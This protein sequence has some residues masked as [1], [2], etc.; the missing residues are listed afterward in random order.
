MHGGTHFQSQHL[1]G[2]GRWISEFEASLVH[3]AS[4]RTAVLVS[5]EKSMIPKDFLSSASWTEYT[6]LIVCRPG[7]ELFQSLSPGFFSGMLIFLKTRF[8]LCV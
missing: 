6:P 5:K 4:S 8:I 7:G 2:R 1:A 3:R